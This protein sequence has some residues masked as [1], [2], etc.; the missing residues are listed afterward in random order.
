MT[1]GFLLSGA[2]AI[3]PGQKKSKPISGQLPYFLEIPLKTYLCPAFG[4]HSA[5][6]FRVVESRNHLLTGPDHQDLEKQLH[7][8]CRLCLIETPYPLIVHI[9]LLA[10]IT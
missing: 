3:R 8:K 10:S 7:A 6:V 5:P 4:A 9:F 1:M 2:D